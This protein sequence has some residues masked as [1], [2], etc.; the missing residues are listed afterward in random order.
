MVCKPTLIPSSSRNRIPCLRSRQSPL[1]ERGPSRQSIARAIFLPT[2]STQNTPY[3]RHGRRNSKNAGSQSRKGRSRN[4][5]SYSIAPDG[6]SPIMDNPFRPLSVSSDPATP[7]PSVSARPLPPLPGYR[8]DM[9]AQSPRGR[10]YHYSQSGRHTTPVTPT[11]PGLSRSHGTTTP[12]EYSMP[13]RP[14]GRS[15]KRVAPTSPPQ[16]PPT[17]PRG[18]NR[19]KH[20]YISD[21]SFKPSA[22]AMGSQTDVSLMMNPFETIGHA[23]SRQGSRKGATLPYRAGC[24]ERR[25]SLNKSQYDT[26]ATIGRSLLAESDSTLNNLNSS[27]VSNWVLN[28]MPS[29]DKNKHNNITRPRP[30]PGGHV[31]RPR[32]QTVSSRS[33]SGHRHRRRNSTSSIKDSGGTNVCPPRRPRPDR[34]THPDLITSSRVATPHNPTVAHIDSDTY[35]PPP[36]PEASLNTSLHGSKCPYQMVSTPFNIDKPERKLNPPPQIDA[37][38][39]QTSARL[40]NAEAVSGQRATNGISRFASPAPPPARTPVLNP[41]TIGWHNANPAH[42]REPSEAST[43]YTDGATL[44]IRNGKNSNSISPEYVFI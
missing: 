10:C 6:N 16:T 36:P 5:Q 40:G 39:D 9:P 13:Q 24:P 32:S 23:L 4:R 43:S 37:N 2:S 42:Q 19:R 35:F 28:R 20:A 33:S 29:M 11:T 15:H 31:S 34:P 18:Q 3:V 17:P 27:N 25:P 26:Y 8:H 38:L 30:Q 1:V 21:N 41:Y 44:P 7:S 14:A 12:V 22:E